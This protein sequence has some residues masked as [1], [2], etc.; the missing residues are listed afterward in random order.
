VDQGADPP[1]A[2]FGK[3]TDSKLHRQPFIG[4]DAIDSARTAGGFPVD[5]DQRNGEAFVPGL[6]QRGF[7]S[8]RHGPA[9]LNAVQT[10][11]IVVRQDL[12]PASPERQ[13]ADQLC[14][15]HFHIRLY[16]IHQLV[17]RNDNHILLLGGQT[18]MVSALPGHRKHML[19]HRIADV[20]MMTEHPRY[21]GGGYSGSFCN[22][23]NSH[24][25]NL[26]CF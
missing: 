13:F 22:L 1:K 6:E 14:H 19:P 3:V 20:R 9:E 5:Q 26:R 8:D 12:D 10:L 17:G 18:R 21:C 25:R 7:E 16:R 11:Q 4:V 15:H 2:A 23:L 24:E